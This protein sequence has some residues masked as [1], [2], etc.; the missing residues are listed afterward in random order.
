MSWLQKFVN[1]TRA[2]FQKRK[3]ESDMAEEMRLHVEHLTRRSIADGLS[4]EEAHY[5][6]QRRFGGIDQFK[7]QCRDGLGWRLVEEFVRD[8]HFGAR[9]LRKNSGFTAVAMLTLAL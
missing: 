4:R 3:L 9:T 8:L 5:A 7:E 1:R 6:A 2:S